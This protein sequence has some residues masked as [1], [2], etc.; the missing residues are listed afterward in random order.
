MWLQV[1]AEKACGGAGPATMPGG[2]APS[3]RNVP[4]HER[5]DGCVVIPRPSPTAD[6]LAGEGVASVMPVITSGNAVDTDV[7]CGRLP[8][9][10]GTLLLEE[11][12][13]YREAACH[14]SAVS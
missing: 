9:N 8:E 7:D 2:K 10:G 5:D 14:A 3:D 12:A 4:T 13:N 6:I 1:L 11:V